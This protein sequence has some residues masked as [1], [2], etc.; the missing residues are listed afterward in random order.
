MSPIVAVGSSDSQIAHGPHLAYPS[1]LPLAGSCSGLTQFLE[2]SLLA[3]T[4]TTPQNTEP[5]VPL[6]YHRGS[7]CMGKV[8]PEGDLQWDQCQVEDGGGPLVFAFHAS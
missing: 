8:F 1:A 6:L 4:H 5:R 7:A 2:T 3:H